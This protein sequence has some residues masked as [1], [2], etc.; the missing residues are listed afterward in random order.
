MN[1]SF[2]IAIPYFFEIFSRS[3]HSS[4][5]P[6]QLYLHPTSRDLLISPVVTVL[7]SEDDHGSEVCN[8]GVQRNKKIFYFNSSL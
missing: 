1:K 4:F 5:Y 7:D 3:P 6:I 2:I 8:V